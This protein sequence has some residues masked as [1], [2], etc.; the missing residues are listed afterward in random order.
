MARTT[1]INRLKIRPRCI[2]RG[3]VGLIATMAVLAGCGAAPGTGKSTSP[4]TPPRPARGNS[5]PSV[6]DGVYAGN[7]G[8]AG[9]QSFERYLGQPVTHV[10]VF[11]DIRKWEY[12]E[13]P[14]RYGLARYRNQPYKLVISVPLLPSDSHDTLQEGA[15]GLLNQ[16]FV[17]LAQSLVSLGMSHAILRLG[18]ELS[19][20]WFSWSA[21]RDPEAYAKYWRQ[22]VTAM[23][24]VP[25][26]HFA[27]DWNGG[28]VGPPGW[29]PAAAY[30]GNQYVDYITMDL[31]DESS[32]YQRNH[33]SPAQIQQW[34]THSALNGPYAL[35]WT[36]KFAAAHGKPFAIPEWGLMRRPD[37]Q[38]GG[39]DTIFLT[40]MYSFLVTHPPAY[41][42]YFEYDMSAG[43]DSNLTDGSFPRSAR[44]FRTL[45]GPSS[46]SG[47]THP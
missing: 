7:S 8:P 13:Y 42:D 14:Q 21:L 17:R 33:P 39:D 37:G 26:T 28:G 45:F 40:D 15:Q 47:S 34:W 22:A 32:T 25:G 10:T 20:D 38:G 24:S 5:S 4:P 30:P 29:N 9:I 3:I 18:W 31:Y 16:H 6:W 27:F 12:M 46:P 36:A 43:Y 11:L 44:L 1:L 23:R 19:G 41:A 35:A 2:W